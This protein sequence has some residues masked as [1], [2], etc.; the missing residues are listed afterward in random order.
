MSACT[1]R[2]WPG[3]RLSSDFGSNTTFQPLGP[4]PESST[5]SAGAVPVLVT[6]IG[7]A[8]ADD[9]ELSGSGPSGWK[10]VFEPKSLD[11]L[12]PGQSREVQALIT[13]SE[14]AVAGDYVTSLRATARG[15]SAS[16]TFRIGVSTSTLWGVTGIGIIAIS[17]LVLVGAVARF[18]R[19]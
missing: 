12:A 4:L 11:N 17:L 6:S 7:I 14:K 5:S 18:G 13:P 9:V 8:P 3:A 15:E 10:V 16:A 2:L 19:R 1:S